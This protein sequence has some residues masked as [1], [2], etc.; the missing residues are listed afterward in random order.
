M[1][2][3]SVAYFLT[4]L[5]REA[6][7][8]EEQ[9]VAFYSQIPPLMHHFPHIFVMQQRMQHQ[10]QQMRQQQMNQMPY[11]PPSSGGGAQG[12]KGGGTDIEALK[13]SGVLALLSSPEGR[14]RVQE[15]AGR[16]QSSRARLQEEVPTWSPER[17]TDYL[18]GF[19]EHPVLVK[20][21]EGG[22][23]DPMA[24][25]NTFVEMSDADLDQ[26]MTL[27][28]VVASDASLA[29]EALERNGSSNS[30]VNGILTTMSS[31]SNFNKFGPPAAPPVTRSVEQHDGH[32]HNGH[33]HGHNH[34]HGESCN[35][36]PVFRSNAKD[37]S[38]GRADTMDR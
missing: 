4:P 20:L 1:S 16:V 24:K 7:F 33:D 17:K 34:A 10:Q 26:M 19:S 21:G 35:H 6:T 31:L 9:R 28:L 5:C 27:M 25:I 18:N 36:N 12:G 15:L 11:P 38:S 29:G 14:L 30:A 37:V 22:D 23:S 3:A 8:S 32:D 2:D 13:Q